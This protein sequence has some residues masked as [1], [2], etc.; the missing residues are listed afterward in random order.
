MNISRPL[1]IALV[2]GLASTNAVGAPPEANLPVAAAKSRL[3]QASDA[4]A[5]AVQKIEKDPPSTPDLDA[6]WAAVG[7]LKDA[8]DAGA[9]NEAA[10]LEYAKAALAAR[11]QLRT[12]REFVEERRAKVYLFN[13][14]RTIDAA[15][16]TMN[17]RAG[18]T[19]RKEAGPKDFEGA[20]AAVAELRKVLDQARP[21]AKEDAAF[22]R[23]L[24]ETDAAAARQEKAIEDRWTLRA[25][26]GHRARVE[27][28][29]QALSAAMATLAKGGGGDAQFAAADA[30]ATGLSKLLDEGRTFEPRDKTYAGVAESAR[31]EVSDARKRMEQLLST[32]ALDRLKSEI[33]PARQDLAAALKVVR[34][35]KPTEDQLAETKTVTIVARGLVE[36]FQPQAAVS[37]PF[38]EYLGQVKALLIEV[39]SE[40]LIRNLESAQAEVTR[41][42]RALERSNPTDEQFAEL[43]TALTILEKTLEG[44]DKSHPIVSSSAAEARALLRDARAAGAQ[45]RGQVDLQRH[46]AK[47]QETKK[48]TEAVVAKIQAP[49]VVEGQFQDAENA[50]K[51][52]KALLDEGAPFIK[53]DRDYAEYDAS[54]KERIAELADR[55]ARRRIWLAAGA[56]K[57]TLTQLM[58]DG[59]TKL[60]AAGRPQATDA[61]LEVASKSVEA[62]TQAIEGSVALEKQDGAYA[63]HAERA[64]NELLRESEAL[65]MAR[66]AVGARKQT[67]NA[68][69]A[70]EVAARAAAEAKDLRTQKKHYDTAMSQFRAC[71][72]DGTQLLKENPDLGKVIA[73]VEGRPRAVQEVVA[74]CSERVKATEQPLRQASSMVAF[75]DG[76][77]KAFEQAKAL[78]ASPR[79]SEAIPHLE[80][81]IVSAARVQS[82]YRELRDRKFAVAGANLTLAEMI[83]TCAADRD[84]LVKK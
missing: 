64:R 63:A 69:A 79:R 53:K 47:I 67:G 19:E 25:V 80:D 76:P 17:G 15:V 52:L 59:K 4:L 23:Y 56:G 54:V 27:A 66:Q 3:Q 8:I 12:Q 11:K 44:V 38:G 31:A 68:L 2:V 78:L 1:A 24:A 62:L 9:A 32:S 49:D 60:E 82:D 77:K 48:N 30:A 21:F 81:C 33:E 14:R 50:L 42:R 58:A 74:T 40:L 35:R 65:E 37:K 61:D 75:E 18:A 6:A 70:G 51:Q 13:H 45:R 83:R 20:R 73:L 29:R 43:T 71:E 28:G 84:T 5:K 55:I 39:E 22:A 36:K 41:T 26:D 57:A 34:G 16:A 7:V 10:D 72:R 46:R